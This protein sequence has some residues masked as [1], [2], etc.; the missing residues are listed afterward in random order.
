MQ[1]LP[2]NNT[3]NKRPWQ[4]RG[5]P[6]GN[7]AFRRTSSAPAATASVGMHVAP[8]QYAGALAPEFDNANVRF[9]TGDPYTVVMK[10]YFVGG[11]GTNF[12]YLYNQAGGNLPYTAY[13]DKSANCG[14]CLVQLQNEIQANSTGFNVVP[15]N[16][17]VV[18]DYEPDMSCSN[19]MP[20]YKSGFQRGLMLQNGTPTV[21]DKVLLEGSPNPASE[22]ME[23]T[24]RVAYSR[25]TT[26]VVRELLSGRIRQTLSLTAKQ[27]TVS[28][29]VAGLT[30]GVYTYSLLADGIPRATRKLVVT[31]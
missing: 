30:P 8:A 18:L 2:L 1:P 4:G 15:S 9:I 12:Q 3:T 25:S 28:V 21:K 29:S 13:L 17:P 11:S 22:T 19:E 14:G 27:G 20:P 16:T 31:H 5:T 26:L 6:C 23:I 7:H 10:N 24:Y